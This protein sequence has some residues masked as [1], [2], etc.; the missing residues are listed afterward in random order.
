M[1]TCSKCKTKYPKES[2]ILYKNQK[3]CQECYKKK[4]KD[5][6]FFNFICLLFGLKS[7]GPKIYSQR[8][9]LRE[10][11]GYTDETIMKT[12]SYL[13]EVKHCN[14]AFESLGLINPKNVEEAISYY[15]KEEYKNKKILDALKQTKEELQIFNVPLLK[16]NNNKLKNKID[17]DNLLLDLE[18]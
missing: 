12:L 4:L 16:E 11:Y 6:E 9:K 18:E 3:F 1:W 7:P 5:E 8:K 13:F 17:L 14:K 2:M 10:N 15:K